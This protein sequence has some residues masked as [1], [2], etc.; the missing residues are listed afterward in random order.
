MWLHVPCCHPIIGT[1]HCCPVGI[2][3][4]SWASTA[5]GH[6]EWQWAWKWCLTQCCVTKRGLLGS[7]QHRSGNGGDVTDAFPRQL[8]GSL[9][10]LNTPLRLFFRAVLERDAGINRPESDR[11]PLQ[12]SACAGDWRWPENA[13]F[14][15]LMLYSPSEEKARPIMWERVFRLRLRQLIPPLHVM[16]ELPF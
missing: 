15:I 5:W 2:C 4:P 16:A 11:A 3:A 1:P 14:L 8:E 13:L 10:V 7:P 12:G 6:S 9:K